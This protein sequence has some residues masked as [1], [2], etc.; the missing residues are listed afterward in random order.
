MTSDSA[1]K[2][3]LPK[4]T[5]ATIRR[6][7]T[8]DVGTNSQTVGRIAWLINFRVPIYAVSSWTSIISLRASQ[9]LDPIR[10]IYEVRNIASSYALEQT[11][12]L[13][14]ICHGLFV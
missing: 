6:P 10:D 4:A 11:W 5:A 12:L 7:D 3:K 8:V 14:Y 1:I 2:K 9:F 13:T